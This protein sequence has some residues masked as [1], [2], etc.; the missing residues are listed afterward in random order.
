MELGRTETCMRSIV[1]GVNCLSVWMLSSLNAEM[2]SVISLCAVVL[3]AYKFMQNFGFICWFSRWCCRQSLLSSQQCK[4]DWV[5]WCHY[6]VSCPSCWM[7]TTRLRWR[8]L[9]VMHTVDWTWSVQLQDVV[10]TVCP[11]VL[12]CG[13]NS[14]S[15]YH[16]YYCTNNSFSSDIFCH[17]LVHYKTNCSG[18]NLWLKYGPLFLLVFS[19]RLV[20]P[21]FNV[22]VE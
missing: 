3:L 4:N 22:Y 5:T 11:A 8:K 14:R 13:M 21:V 6:H 17:L 9:S 20:G 19:A 15:A 18:C 10:R 12:P 1:R 2:L 16:C 7:S